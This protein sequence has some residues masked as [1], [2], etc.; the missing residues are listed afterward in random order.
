MIEGR[1]RPRIGDG[2]MKGGERE[3]LGWGQKRKEKEVR[4]ARSERRKT[5]REKGT[6]VALCLLLLQEIE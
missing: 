2:N 1:Y 5:K 4:G 6:Q 3:N